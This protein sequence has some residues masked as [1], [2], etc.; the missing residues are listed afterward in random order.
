MSFLEIV[1]AIQWNKQSGSKFKFPV[2]AYMIEHIGMPSKEPVASPRPD[3]V[4]YAFGSVFFASTPTPH[5]AGT[6][7]HV[8]ITDSTGIMTSRPAASIQI[9]TFPDGKL[10]ISKLVNGQPIGGMPPT[11][12]QGT[13]VLDNLVTATS[14]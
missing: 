4:W 6:L 11:Q 3:I 8:Q 10:L 12:L 9:Q 14:Q 7:S 13:D 1:K 5:L 2:N